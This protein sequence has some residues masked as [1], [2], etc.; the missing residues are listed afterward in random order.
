M[1]V[2][3]LLYAA[4]QACWGSTREHPEPVPSWAPRFQTF[5]SVRVLPF[6]HSVVPPTAVTSG[7]TAGH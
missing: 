6:I 1:F 3:A 4:C 5:S 2:Q 7:E